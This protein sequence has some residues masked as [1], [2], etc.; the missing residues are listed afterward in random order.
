MGLWGKC[1][2]CGNELGFMYYNIT[3]THDK[4]CRNCCEKANKPENT[5]IQENGKY[6]I[7]NNADT[8]KRI[9]CNN[10]GHTYCY[11]QNDLFENLKYQQ[12]AKT[13][14]VM[15]AIGAV[16]GNRMDVYANGQEVDSSLGKIVDYTH[17]PK[18]NSQD[19]REL[20]KEEWD[21]EKAA[22]NS[23]AS[24]LSAADEIKKYKDLLDLG[25]LTQEEFNQKK[26]QLM[27][28]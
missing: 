1:T 8:E 5:I 10:C 23:Q 11:T 26:K 7:V 2:I 17:C 6:R 14:A 4:V 13:A 18:C 16:G 20:S 27:G 25:V 21:R 24:T 19:L 28:L 3:G 15:S 9:K 22:Q 12:Q